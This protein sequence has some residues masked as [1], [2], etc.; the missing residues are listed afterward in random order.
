MVV[1]YAT[2][3][4]RHI[5][6]P[7]VGTVCGRGAL[8]EGTGAHS[9]KPAMQ[10]CRTAVPSKTSSLQ[11]EHKHGALLAASVVAR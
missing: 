1:K 7:M 5:E 11:A 8:I 9:Y 4:T 3:H 10:M 2:C 6:A